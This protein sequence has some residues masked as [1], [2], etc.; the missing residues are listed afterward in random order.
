MQL[1]RY[2][3]LNMQSPRASE[4]FPPRLVQRSSHIWCD[5]PEALGEGALAPPVAYPPPISMDDVQGP[6]FIGAL[7][8]VEVPTPGISR[9]SRGLRGSSRR[10]PR[11]TLRS[12]LTR[13]SP[14][15]G[16]DACSPDVATDT[17][18][19]IRH[20]WESLARLDTALKDAQCS[21]SL[22]MRE[23]VGT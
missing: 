18:C 9:I 15:K 12:V 19:P 2:C 14:K 10:V 6:P 13:A 20:E 8:A 7:R 1:I 11:S 21:R 5:E 22:L 3:L 17:T 4:S 23:N 16:V